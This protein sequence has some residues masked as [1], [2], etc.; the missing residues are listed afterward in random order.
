MGME[1]SRVIGNTTAKAKHH[2]KGQ[3]KGNPVIPLI[4]KPLLYPLGS[5]KHTLKNNLRF[6]ILKKSSLLLYL[7]S[8]ACSF[9]SPEFPE[10]IKI[11]IFLFF[12]KSTNINKKKKT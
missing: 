1:L 7:R 2:N 4:H 10:N 8:P 3:K 9:L 12:F 6:G 5:S 11:F